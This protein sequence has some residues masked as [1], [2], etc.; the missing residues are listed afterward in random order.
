MS[1]FIIANI[2]HPLTNHMR[3]LIFSVLPIA[4]SEHVFASE[5]VSRTVFFPSLAWC[6]RAY[7][8]L[9]FWVTGI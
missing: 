5:A 1:Y 9:R 2:M 7:G 4:E 6:W 8:S 3:F